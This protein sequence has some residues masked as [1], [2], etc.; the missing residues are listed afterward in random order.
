MPIINIRLV[1]L[2]IGCLTVVLPFSAYACGGGKLTV[3][4]ATVQKVI[5]GTAQGKNKHEYVLKLTSKGKNAISI[6]HVWIKSEDGKCYD[7]KYGLMD[8]ANSTTLNSVPSKVAFILAMTTRDSDALT[9]CPDQLKGAAI[10]VYKVGSK[11]KYLHI[12]AFEKLKDRR[13]R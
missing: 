10:I 9:D 6:E 7:A 4:K 5:R 13:L 11:T 1:S 12:D 2:L 8:A 3:S